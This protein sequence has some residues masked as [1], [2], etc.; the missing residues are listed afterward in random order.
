MAVD[1]NSINRTDLGALIAG[2]LAL[3]FSFI[4]N[5][6]SFSYDVPDDVEA[7]GAA[8]ASGGLSSA[9]VSYATLGMLL[10]LAATAI[11]AVKVFAGQVL[12]AGVPFNL[13]A[14][15]AAGLGTL[16]I[17]LKAVTASDGGSA[18]GFETSVG[19]GWSAWPLFLCAIA[20]TA[21]AALGFRDSG[22]NVPWNNQGSSTGMASSGY[23]GVGDGGY[24][25]A[26]PAGPPYS[27][28]TAAPPPPSGGAPM[29]PPPPA[30]GTG[31]VGS[32]PPPPPPASGEE[33]PRSAY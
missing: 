16:L 12:P 33:P 17:I 15:A 1:I 29:A 31:A 3:I 7:L 6:I 14:A 26:P 4:G 30:P 27:G 22:E 23:T 5:Y 32:V 25:S 20:L 19:P 8:D 28:G 9:W 21:F 2:A 10:I 11:I 18:L 13:V 24:Q